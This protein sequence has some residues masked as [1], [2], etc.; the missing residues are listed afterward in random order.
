MNGYS[1]PTPESI[2]IHVRPLD[3]TEV[4]PGA[5]HHYLLSQ[6]A[7]ALGLGVSV[8]R[9]WSCWSRSHAPQKLSPYLFP[10]T[11]DANLVVLV[12]SPPHPPPLPRGYVIMSPLCCPSPI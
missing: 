3:L 9:G 7:A 2:D 10:L 8:D 5:R 6:T 1:Y 11:V 4:E 12:L